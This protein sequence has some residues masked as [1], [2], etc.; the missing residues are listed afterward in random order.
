M[1]SLTPLDES[2]PKENINMTDTEDKESYDLIAL[3]HPR[4]KYTPQQ[5]LH[6]VSVYML[7]GNLKKAADNAGIN[8]EVVKD[9]KTRSSWWE[10]ALAA[11][12]KNKQDELDAH[13]TDI[14]D[15]CVSEITDR[16]VNGDEVITKIGTRE[17]KQIS[18]RDAAWIAGVLF[19]KRALIR[20]DPT[21]RSERS[22]KEDDLNQLLKKFEDLSK[23]MQEK[24]IEGE[25]IKDAKEVGTET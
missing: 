15:C 16:L 1:G 7:T 24:T 4:S 19:D 25:V 20:G 23:K 9:W 12:R 2:M 22:S 13:I 11:V 8:Y 14:L 18:A 21:S 10:D 5:K 6:V 17:R 3:D